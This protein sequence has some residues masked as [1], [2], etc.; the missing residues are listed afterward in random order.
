MKKLKIML[1][2]VAFLFALVAAFASKNVSSTDTLDQYYRANSSGQCV[3]TNCDPLNAGELCEF[4]V[5]QTKISQSQCDNPVIQA[6][7]P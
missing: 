3:Q 6:R 2:S 5:Y 1:A 4:T 7:R